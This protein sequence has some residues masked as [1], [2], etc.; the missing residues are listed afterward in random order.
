MTTIALYQRS[1]ESPIEDLATKLFSDLPENQRILRFRSFSPERLLH[2]YNS[3]LVQWLLLHAHAVTIRTKQQ[4]TKAWRQF[5]RHLRFHQL[6][7]QIERKRGGV[8]SITVDG[9]MSLFQQTKKYG[10]SLASFFPAVLHLHEWQLAADI[11]LR[12]RKPKR[13]RLDHTAGLRPLL[14]SFPSACARRDRHVPE[15][16]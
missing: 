16:L 5:F 7:A 14:R 3:A 2:R 4:D 11:H 15:A 6:L 12:N 10:L 9:P 8:F 1:K 13:L